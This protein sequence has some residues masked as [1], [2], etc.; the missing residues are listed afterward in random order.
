MTNTITNQSANELLELWFQ[1]SVA[2]RKLED[3]VFRQCQRVAAKLALPQT[4]PLRTA[5]CSLSHNDA[6]AL[7]HVG[8]DKIRKAIALPA[9]HPLYLPSVM[10]TGRGG[11][12]VTHRLIREEDAWAWHERYVKDPAAALTLPP[13]K[14]GGAK[15]A[16]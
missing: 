15:S 7:L 1:T 8:K 12:G 10:T 16:K 3:E 6:A 2:L 11:L 9:D 14:K 13:V 4:Q 5:P